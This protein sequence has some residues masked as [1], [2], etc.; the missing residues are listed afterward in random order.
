MKSTNMRIYL[1]FMVVCMICPWELVT[2]LKY[3][4]QYL[5]FIYH[6]YIQQLIITAIN[7]AWSWAYRVISL[8]YN[9]KAPFSTCFKVCFSWKLNSFYQCVHFS[10]PIQTIDQRNCT[11]YPSNRS[12]H[13]GPT[14][15]SW[16][17]VLTCVV[18]SNQIIK[19]NV[20]MQTGQCCYS[21]ASIF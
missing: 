7:H 1:Y 2:L 11:R 13:I 21:G 6:V 17:A 8:L 4:I 15:N 12:H 9:F 20:W 5:S 18:L 10:D 16:L 19:W 14:V 3:V